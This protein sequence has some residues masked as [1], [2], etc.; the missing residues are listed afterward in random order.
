MNNAK[1]LIREKNNM[2]ICE[3]YMDV[4]SLY[5]NNIK[6]CVAPLGTAFTEEQLNKLVES[7][8]KLQVRIDFNSWLPEKL[9]KFIST[10]L[11]NYYLKEFSKNRNLQSNLKKI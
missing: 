7:T 10:K 8:R 5:E 2:L 6:T 3:G 1:K 9:E 4:I 11:C